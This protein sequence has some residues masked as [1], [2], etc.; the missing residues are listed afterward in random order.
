MRFITLHERL[1]TVIRVFGQFLTSIPRKILFAFRNLIVSSFCK[2]FR[3]MAR[4]GKVSSDDDR[5]AEP[6]PIEIERE[7][8]P[9]TSDDDLGHSLFNRPW[10]RLVEDCTELYSEIADRLP[11]YDSNQLNL[12]HHVLDRLLEIL[13][14]NGVTIISGDHVFDRTRHTTEGRPLDVPAD[15]PILATISPGFAIEKRVLRKAVVKIEIS[16]KST[17]NSEAT[18]ELFHDQPEDPL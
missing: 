6:G 12:A 13:E 14:R 1:P 7:D 17:D 4:E 9:V 2:I 16:G 3:H 8:R 10:V 15:S 5:A 11:C 18:K